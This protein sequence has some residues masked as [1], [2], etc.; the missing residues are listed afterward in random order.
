MHATWLQISH[1]ELYMGWDLETGG[2]VWVKLPGWLAREVWG[3][4]VCGLFSGRHCRQLTGP[5]PRSAQRW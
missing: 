2:T 3:S 1:S 4:H 5:P